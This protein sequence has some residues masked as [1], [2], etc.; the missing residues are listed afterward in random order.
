[1]CEKTEELVFSTGPLD[2]QLVN[3]MTVYILKTLLQLLYGDNIGNGSLQRRKTKLG[4][5]IWDESSW[6]D[7][8]RKTKKNFSS[9]SIIFHKAQSTQLKI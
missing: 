8:Q 7:V 9:E 3:S 4:K 5:E 2:F 6:K 1:M